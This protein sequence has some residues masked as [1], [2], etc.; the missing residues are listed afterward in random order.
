MK[1]KILNLI[2]SAV[3]F[4]LCLLV[5]AL[6]FEG[7]RSFA[8]SNEPA[9]ELGTAVFTKNGHDYL[10]VD[11]KHGVCVIHAESCPCL[12]K[13][14]RMSLEKKEKLTAY[15][16]KKENCIGAYHPLGF[17]TQTDAHYLFDNVFTKEFVKEMTDRGYDVTTM[18]FEISPKLPNYER[19]NGLSKKYCRKEKQRMKKQI[20]LDE[21]DIKEFHE[22]AEH[23]RWLYNRMVR[24]HSENEDFD[25]MH[26]FNKIINKLEQLQRM[27]I[28]LAKKIW[29]RATNKMSSYWLDKFVKADKL[30]SRI[31]QAS[32]K[33]AKWE[34]NNI[35]N[36]LEKSVRITP[37]EV[38]KI[39]KSAELLNCP[40]SE[41]IK[42][43]KQ[44]LK[45][46]KK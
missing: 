41:C 32:R 25:Y 20:V 37:S 14:Q 30:D 1:N 10:L 39:R 2:K 11:T 4:V 34:A 38:K 18:K 42:V 27:K 28:R 15:W 5:G 43:A 9:K 45:R 44:Q 6:I 19:F 33:L 8:N 3:W 24:E 12:K 22:D 17:M 29:N 21:Q 46:K 26:R 13:K 35:K 16:D 31:T 36:R 40:L 23:L 7:I